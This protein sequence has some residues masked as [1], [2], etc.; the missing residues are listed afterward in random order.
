MGAT[1][2]VVF[3]V[4]FITGDKNFGDDTLNY[5]DVSLTKKDAVQFLEEGNYY[6]TRIE[7]PFLY[8][9]ALTRVECGYLSTN[10][11][12][13]EVVEHHLKNDSAEASLRIFDNQEGADIYTEHLRVR[14]QEL[15]FEKKRGNY[16]LKIYK[17]K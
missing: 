8:Q 16:W 4:V 14:G 13:K 12:F 17:T 3:S 6:T 5:A 9:H 1:I 11:T 2:A 10:N 15:I 7:A